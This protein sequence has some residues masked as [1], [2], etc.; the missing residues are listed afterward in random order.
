MSK[1]NT[2]IYFC[3]IWFAG[4]SSTVLANTPPTTV[5][6][7]AAGYLTQ[8]VGGLVLVILLILVMAWLLRRLPGIMM[9]GS[10]VIEIL[11]VRVI[12]NR[13]RLLLIQIGEEQL[14]V[15]ATPAGL[16]HLHTLQT[17]VAV[18]LPEPQT[19]DFAKLLNKIRNSGLKP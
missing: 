1:F 12:G 15:G 7:Q 17:P 14:L 18:S 13:E 5:S 9:Q 8:L 10:P 6:T 3:G 19:N 4:I 2:L 11:A 16:C